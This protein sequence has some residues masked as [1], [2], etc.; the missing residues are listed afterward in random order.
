MQL[1]RDNQ[2]FQSVPHCMTP[3][4][5]ISLIIFKAHMY[6]LFIVKVTILMCD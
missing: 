6:I 3:L 5:I 4:A 2:Q 1:V